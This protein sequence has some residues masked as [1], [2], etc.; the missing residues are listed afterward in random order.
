MRQIFREE[1]S[2]LKESLDEKTK[3]LDLLV[4][5]HRSLRAQF[6]EVIVKLKDAEAD[7][8]KL[9]DRWMLEKMQD[10]ERLNEVFF[11]FYILVF[12]IL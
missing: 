8:K 9:I 3:A 11:S 6:E 7:N 12:A 4:D 10:A 1:N 2:K 5:E